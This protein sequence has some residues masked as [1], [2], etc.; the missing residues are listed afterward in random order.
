MGAVTYPDAN[1]VDFINE[2]FVPI[3][4]AYDAKPESVDYNVKWTPAAIIL[5]RDGKE[6]SRNVGFLTPDDFI[7]FMM[8]GMGKTSFDYDDFDL[9]LDCF[10]R[11]MDEY[12]QSK[13]APEAFY[14]RGVCLFKKTHEGKPLKEAYEELVKRY[15]DGE[16]TERASPYRLL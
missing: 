10:N 3:Q 9:A 4:L 15:P 7:P 13:S 12:P 8:L 6:H 1:V 5:D 11:I 14:M 16:W 2:N